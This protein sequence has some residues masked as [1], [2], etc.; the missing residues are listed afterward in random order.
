MEHWVSIEDF[1]GLYEVSNLGNI[2]SLD[3][4]ILCKNGIVHHITGKVL[5]TSSY[6]ENYKQAS[7]YK[8]R[9]YYHRYVHRLVAE[10][11][12]P[13][14]ENLPQVNHKDE[15]K[16]NNCVSNLEWITPKDNCNYGTRNERQGLGHSKPIQQY[17]L[18]GNFIK[19]WESAAEVEKV[20]G[21]NHSNISK[22][23]LRRYNVAYNYKWKFK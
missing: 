1:E 14:P 11:F 10:A 22:C 6:K 5:D 13:N 4:D 16:T 23:C 17:D 20:L 12:I 2:R 7:L 3:R 9:K 21:F 15:D 8:D 18:E 19:E